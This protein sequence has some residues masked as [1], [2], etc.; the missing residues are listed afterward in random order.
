MENL[1]HVPSERNLRTERLIFCKSLIYRDGDL[2]RDQQ[3]STKNVSPPSRQWTSCLDS[4]W[5][6]PSFHSLPING[7][8]RT[9]PSMDVLELATAWIS[10]IAFPLLFPINSIYGY[11]SLLL[12]TSLVRST[13]ITSNIPKMK[14]TSVQRSIRITGSEWLYSFYPQIYYAA[15]SALTHKR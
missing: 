14:V 7:I 12:F 8:P 6:C 5:I 2:P 11:L 13:S 1:R 3:T 9:E 10:R 4:D 15:K